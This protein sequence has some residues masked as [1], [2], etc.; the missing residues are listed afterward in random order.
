MLKSFV[1]IGEVRMRGNG[2]IAPVTKHEALKVHSGR[3]IKGT[4]IPWK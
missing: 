2:A 4:R 3:E 1:E